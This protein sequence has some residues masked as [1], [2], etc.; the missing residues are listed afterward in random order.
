MIANDTLLQ[1]LA[2]GYRRREDKGRQLLAIF[3]QKETPIGTSFHAP[4][5]LQKLE[6]SA[7]RRARNGQG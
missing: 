2:R 1:Q 7:D 4:M 3:Q 5:M 6:R